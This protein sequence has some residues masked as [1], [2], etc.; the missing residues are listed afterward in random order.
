MEGYLKQHNSLDSYQAY[1]MGA[2]GEKTV[3]L[4]I[5]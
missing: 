2:D 3:L 4:G 5:Q 1:L